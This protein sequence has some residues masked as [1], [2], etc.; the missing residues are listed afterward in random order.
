MKAGRGRGFT[1]I[2]LLVVIAIIAILAA[3]LFP[4]FAR[5]R[6][7]ARMTSCLSNMKQLGLGILMYTS[8]YDEMLC[9]NSHP[10]CV[11]CFRSYGNGN[12]TNANWVV[13]ISPYV[14]NAAIWKCPSARNAWGASS[15]TGGGSIPNAT[16]YVWNGHLRT[17][18]I[19][20]VGQPAQCPV[21]VEWCSCD[22]GAVMRPID[23]CNAQNWGLPYNDPASF[24][25]VQHAALS[26]PTTE[27]GSYNVTFLDGHAKVQN[28]RRLW[29]IDYPAI[30]PSGSG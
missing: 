23:C 30:H 4:V 24:W 18:P 21:L 22:Q 1:L 6:E 3:I 28:P 16:N 19:A 17:R 5:A 29:T 11:C 13:E 14:K 25:G 7:K 27:D 26:G 10:C 8:D 20:R 9:H 15:D 12:N 2:E